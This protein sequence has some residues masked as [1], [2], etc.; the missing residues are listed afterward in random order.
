[1]DEL[2]NEL[3][4]D[5]TAELSVADENFNASLLEIK[6]KGAY[7]EVKKAR[8]FPSNYTDEMINEE[9]DNFYSIIRSIALFDYN[10]IGAEFQKSS[11]ENSVSR[12]WVNRETLFNGI[13]P[14]SR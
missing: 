11:N 12:T 13:I 14:I 5:L 6:I 7:K 4:D 2:I 1:M 10:T 9:M 8:N 3:L